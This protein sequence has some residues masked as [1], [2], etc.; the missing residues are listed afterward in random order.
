MPFPIFIGNRPS[1]VRKSA[2]Y[3]IRSR[4][5]GHVVAIT[6][7]ADE[8]ERWYPTSD[9][10]PELVKMV[11]DVKKTH[12]IAP[13]GSF[14]INEYHQVIVPV[15]GGSRD[16]YLAGEY[17]KP[18]RFEFEGRQI[19]GE[20]INLEGHP[21]SP[22][23]LWT[24]PHAGIPYKLAAG[25]YDIYYTF[26]PRPDVEKKVKLSAQIG[27]EK[28]SIAATPIREIAGTSGG[29]FYVNE[30]G[31]IFKPMATNYGIEYLYVGQIDLSNWF[32]KPLH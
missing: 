18:L 24:G 16:Y 27:I 4:A 6:Y 14:Y 2:K 32:N 19:S 12:G 10:H 7:E 22:G 26:S 11:N 20:A 21:L 13:G 1:N 25:G 28:A 30:F 5:G 15:A 17:H 31:C 8:G 29:R 3:Q 9:Q 23:A